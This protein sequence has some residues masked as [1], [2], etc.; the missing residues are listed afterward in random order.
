MHAAHPAA[1]VFINLGPP[2][3][4]TVTHPPEVQL[5]LGRIV[6]LHHRTLK[7][8]AVWDFWSYDTIQTVWGETES[9]HFSIDYW[10]RTGTTTKTG[11]MDRTTSSDCSE[12]LRM[13]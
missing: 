7:E 4:H 9:H 2:A 11:P 13:G 6:A 3:D 12:R 10:Y 5:W 1:L 8:L